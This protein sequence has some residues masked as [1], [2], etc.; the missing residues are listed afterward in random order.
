MVAQGQHGLMSLHF[1]AH[2]SW[3]CQGFHGV[4]WCRILHQRIPSFGAASWLININLSMRKPGQV[5]SGSKKK[6]TKVAQDGFPSEMTL[7]VW[8]LGKLNDVGNIFQPNIENQY[9]ELAKPWEKMKKAHLQLHW[10]LS[11]CASEKYIHVIYLSWLVAYWHTC[12][13]K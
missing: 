8:R 9:M 1:T 3:E 4:P 13:L 6:D 12:I 11:I 5:W 10:H 2:S 7:W